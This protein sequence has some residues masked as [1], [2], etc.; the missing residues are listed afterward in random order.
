MKPSFFL[1]DSRGG[2]GGGGIDLGCTLSWR[3]SSNRNLVE[4]MGLP[5]PEISKAVWDMPGYRC[6]PGDKMVGRP[7][8]ISSVLGAQ[9]TQQ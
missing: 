4:S 6:C 8:T 9:M 1:L 2:S 3:T 7:L 5:R